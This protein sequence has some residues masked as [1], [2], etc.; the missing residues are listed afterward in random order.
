MYSSS[1]A[2]TAST[3]DVG[4]EETSG[5]A[6]NAP[7]SGH[8]LR[9]AAAGS[10][11]AW[12]SLVERHTGLL[13]A[14]AR[15]FRLGDAS[16]ADVVQTAWLRLAE[17]IDRVRDPDKVGVWL[18]TTVRRECLRLLQSRS[19]EYLSDVLD[20]L[21]LADDQRG[22]EATAVA[23]DR[24]LR[25]QAA[26]ARLPERD[27]RLLTVLM[28]SPPPSYVEVAASLDMPIGSIGPTR[29][30]CLARLRKELAAVGLDESMWD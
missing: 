22:P 28:A 19:R 10:E 9:R 25:V 29:A 24:D 3:E 14:V 4:I 23:C 13:W 6:P 16:S 20:D 11:S 7:A 30:R 2:V 26:L 15:S 5:D 1:E 18:A 8:L 12:G 27:Q 21:Q 17:N